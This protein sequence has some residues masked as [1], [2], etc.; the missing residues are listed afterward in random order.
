MTQD[1]GTRGF[2]KAHHPRMTRERRTIE[3]MIDLY[4]HDQHGAGAGLC[5]DCEALRSYARQRLQKCGM[6]PYAVI[7]ARY[8]WDEN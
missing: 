7:P 8:L 1:N 4:C 2:I 5:P 6:V 3:A